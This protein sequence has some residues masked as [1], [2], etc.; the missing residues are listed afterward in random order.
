MINPVVQR[1]PYTPKTGCIL[2]GGDFIVKKVE[3]T[4]VLGQVIFACAAERNPWVSLKSMGVN[5]DPL[6]EAFKY[7]CP[8][9]GNTFYHFIPVAIVIKNDVDAYR[10][11]PYDLKDFDYMFD[12]DWINNDLLRG[13]HPEL[14]TISES[15]LGH[16][17]TTCTLP[18]DGDG[19]WI[20][21][22]IELDNGD[23][24]FGVCWEWYNK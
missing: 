3:K 14:N 15:M 21:V 2:S 4:D 6:V 12:L 8:Y 17:F 19:G 22:L 20:E 7:E 10:K 5:S 13:Q 23:Y 1:K 18:T 11:S 24:L 16:G 9:T